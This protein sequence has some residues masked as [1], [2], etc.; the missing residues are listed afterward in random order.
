M[1]AES[2]QTSETF[3]SRFQYPRKPNEKAGVFL[4]PC[5]M[6]I[7]YGLYSWVLE[8][9][10]QVERTRVLADSLKNAPACPCPSTQSFSGESCPSKRLGS[11]LVFN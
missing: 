7:S 10:A 5:E 9:L 6:F 4:K 11:L 8:I 2:K 1:T 3:S